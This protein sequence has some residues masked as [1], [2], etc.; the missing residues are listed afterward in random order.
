MKTYLLAFSVLA[1]AATPAAAQ[2]AKEGQTRTAVSAN[3][4][5]RF[6]KMDTDG[7]GSVSQAEFTAFQQSK[8]TREG[9]T[10]KPR[11]ATKMFTK[12]DANGDG[13]LSLDEFKGR[14]LAMFDARDVNKNGKIDAD[15]VSPAAG[16]SETEGE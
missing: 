4:E 16:S 1:I 14:A 7:N 6:H 9:G 8:A 13:A 12:T 5:R 2:K 15:E 10:F 3:V 11:R